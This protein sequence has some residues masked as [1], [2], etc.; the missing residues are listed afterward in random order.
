MA[1]EAIKFHDHFYC[2]NYCE[3]QICDFIGPCNC[4]R[5][6]VMLTGKR[7]CIEQNKRNDRSLKYYCFTNLFHSIT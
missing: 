4:I 5:F 3:E 1:T 2:K 6:F 7:K